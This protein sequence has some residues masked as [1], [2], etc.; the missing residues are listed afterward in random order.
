MT[1]VMQI[2]KQSL[3][4]PQDVVV[5]IKFFI[6]KHQQITFA[7]LALELCLST[8]EV[9][10]AYKRAE[11]AGLMH[12]LNGSPMANRQ[13][14]SEFLVHG[15]KYAF[16]AS[17]GAPTRG[18][19]TGLAAS[20]IKS[21]FPTAMHAPYVWPDAHGADQ[22]ISLLPLYPTIPQAARQDLLLYEILA[23]VD[24]LRAGAARERE[25]AEV[26]LAKRI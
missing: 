25:M 24:M 7:K 21:L 5:A 12:C 15:V 22:G 13:P 23:L 1:A 20:P 9:H 6:A 3:L 19:L 14:L 4:K 10:G 17:T 8:S 16:P 2:Q 18:M 26:E 11:M